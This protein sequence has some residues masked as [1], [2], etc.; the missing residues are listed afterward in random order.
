MIK[1][2][3]VLSKAY[4]QE[5]RSEQPH[6]MVCLRHVCLALLVKIMLQISRTNFKAVPRLFQFLQMS[7]LDILLGEHSFC[8]VAASNV[9]ISGE[10]QIFRLSTSS[11]SRF[12][13][14]SCWPFLRFFDFFRNITPCHFCFFM[15]SFHFQKKLL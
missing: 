4:P 3:Y 11:G 8:R 1:E 15:D 14:T 13:V 2:F 6:Q 10:G 12:V 5:I 9:D 7:L